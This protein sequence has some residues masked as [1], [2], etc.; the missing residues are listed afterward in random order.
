[1]LVAQCGGEGNLTRFL[2]VAAEVS[3][4]APYRE[5]LTGFTLPKRFAAAAATADRLRAAGFGPVQAWR[6]PSVITP[7]DPVGLVRTAPLRCH[8]Q[9]LPEELH[10]P[11]I[12]EVLRR[13][14]EPLRLDFQRLNIVATRPRF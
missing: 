8:L 11:F 3:A 10:E 4:E 7:S 5:H 6:E 12:A 2:G 14:G 9:R 13:C 1:V